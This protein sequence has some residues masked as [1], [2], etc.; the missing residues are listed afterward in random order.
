MAYDLYSGKNIM[1]YYSAMLK[2]KY[3]YINDGNIDEQ[4]G[5]EIFWNC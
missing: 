2:D 1:D 3:N 4:L 5:K